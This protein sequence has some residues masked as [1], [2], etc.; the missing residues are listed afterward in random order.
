MIQL[1]VWRGLYVVLL[2]YCKPK[3]DLTK[4]KGRLRLVEN[5]LDVM[6]IFS[7]I[8][9]FGATDSS[10]W[11]YGNTMDGVIQHVTKY[12]EEPS[13][14]QDISVTILDLDH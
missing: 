4:F 10:I 14:N 13:D 12:F 6:K 11:G 5:N 3:L 1:P 9:L 8:L 2:L 7:E